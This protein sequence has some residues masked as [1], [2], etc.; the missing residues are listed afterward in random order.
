MNFREKW[1]PAVESVL[2]ATG[3][4]LLSSNSISAFVSVIASLSSQK[5][6]AVVAAV[7]G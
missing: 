6:L 2:L 3:F 5:G 7:S 1:G 4:L